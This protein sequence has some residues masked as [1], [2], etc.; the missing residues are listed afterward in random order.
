VRPGGQP[1]RAERG[2]GVITALV[3]K[4]RRSERVAVHVDG[5]FAFDVSAA[6][7]AEAGLERGRLL[8][9]EDQAALVKQDGPYRAR[10]KA[11][12]LLALRE[13]SRGEVEERL[14]AAGFE[15][16]VVLDTLH[17]LERL[18]YVDDRRY[19]SAYVA[20]RVAS[21]WGVRRIKSELLRKGV[22]RALVEEALRSTAAEAGDEAAGTDAVMALSRRRFAAQFQT[23]PATAR[24]RLAGFLARRGYDWDSIDRISAV[25]SREAAAPADEEL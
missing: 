7:A 15:D 13:R 23:D 10:D 5:A 9:G 16:A 11:L 4:K 2:P 20:E 18:G 24:R 19:A 14:R 25:L 17:W 21:G 22:E 3:T 6:V 8:S 1:P 12:G